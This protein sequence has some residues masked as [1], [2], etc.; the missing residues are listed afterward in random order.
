MSI[1]GAE[2][3]KGIISNMWGAIKGVFAGDEVK[4]EE[5]LVHYGPQ[6]ATVN[7]LLD[8][9]TEEN[10][11]L[12]A[13]LQKGFMHQVASY[14]GWVEALDY[15]GDNEV[16]IQD[17]Q[18][19]VQDN[20]YTAAALGVA[21]GVPAVYVAGKSVIGA[22]KNGGQ[23]TLD[24]AT[25]AKDTA[26]Y[27]PSAVYNKTIGSSHTVK[28]IEGPKVASNNPFNGTNK[29]EA[30]AELLKDNSDAPFVKWMQS[31]DQ[32]FVDVLEKFTSEGFAR[33]AKQ[34]EKS[35]NTFVNLPVETFENLFQK[36]IEDAHKK[37]SLVI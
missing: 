32:A 35:I 34:G 5:S 15:N 26:L 3:G 23:A 22:L 16:S 33:L 28:A 1:N 19:V 14:F 4:V 29:E 8:I 30:F 24:V 7:E 20:P 36:S 12:K 9:A 21:V 2:Q 37:K 11:E 31:A 10:A 18:D 25:T 17:L 13:E 6:E 27:I